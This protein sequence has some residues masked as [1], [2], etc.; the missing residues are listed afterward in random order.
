MTDVVAMSKAGVADDLIITHIRTH[1]VATLPTSDEII[2]LTQ[3]GVSPAV[4]KAMQSPMPP[5]GAMAPPGQPVLVPGAVPA[6]VI[7]EEYHYGPPP[8]HPPYRYGCR[9]GPGVSWGM[10]VSN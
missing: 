9:P 8:F 6:P 7:V 10:A 2:F 3:Q 5:Q 4:I 1:G